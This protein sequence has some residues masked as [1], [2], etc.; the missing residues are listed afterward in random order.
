VH[1]PSSHWFLPQ[2]AFLFFSS[3]FF[4]SL[5]FSL[6]VP[7]RMNRKKGGVFFLIKKK[8]VKRK[9]NQLLKIFRVALVHICAIKKEKIRRKIKEK[10]INQGRKEGE[11]KECK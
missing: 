4:G 11:K 6:L 5:A 9:E 10:R 8:K 7:Q 2:K 1:L 3:C